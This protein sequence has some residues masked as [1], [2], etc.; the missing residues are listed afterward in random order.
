MG[1]LTEARTQQAGNEKTLEKPQCPAVA[2]IGSGG[3]WQ[4]RLLVEQLRLQA[5][6]R[7]SGRTAAGNGTF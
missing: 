6:R 5:V 1:V 4:W 3:Y 2:V 7:G